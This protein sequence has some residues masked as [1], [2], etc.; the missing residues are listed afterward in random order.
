VLVGLTVPT[1]DGQYGG[2]KVRCD[3]PG[4]H[5]TEARHEPC[6]LACSRRCWRPA[7]QS[8]P[9]PN[10]CFLV[11]CCLSAGW[12]HEQAQQ[13]RPALCLAASLVYCVQEQ[14][15]LLEPPTTVAVCG[16]LPRPSPDASSSVVPYSNQVPANS[17]HLTRW[18]SGGWRGEC[19][20]AGICT[21]GSFPKPCWW[22][23][24]YQHWCRSGKVCCCLWQAGHVRLI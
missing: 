21:A 5:A 3:P 6:V 12:L 17:S 18:C 23:L 15:S 13:G 24:T 16:P 22:S 2:H 14:D 8:Q 11:S 20:S 7:G 19:V 9:G 10:L 4:P 1:A